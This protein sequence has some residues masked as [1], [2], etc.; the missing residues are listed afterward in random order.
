MADGGMLVCTLECSKI[1]EPSLPPIPFSNPRILINFG[2]GHL[3][4]PKGP[5]LF[6]ER[7]LH[8]FGCFHFSPYSEVQG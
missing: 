5:L 1:K 6:P 4:M 7:P 8:I 3:S 2:Y